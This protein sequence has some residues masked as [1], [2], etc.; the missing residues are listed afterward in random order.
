MDS[1]SPP[2][3]S[4]AAAAAAS[5]VPNASS[6][7]SSQNAAAAPL[8]FQ[9]PT[10]TLRFVMFQKDVGSII[11]KGGATIKTFREESGARINI[12]DSG[13]PER[14]V[15]IH[16]TT[17]GIFKAVAL[18]AKKFEEDHRVAL[19]SGTGTP[20]PPVS[21]R[22]L[23]PA[24]QC[25]PLIGKRGAR[26]KEIRESTRAALIQVSGDL[27]PGSTE[28][29]VTLSG[30][31]DALTQCIYHICC[32]IVENPPRTATVFYKPQM[33]PPPIVLPGIGPMS[34]GDPMVAV[35][36][37]DLSPPGH[38]PPPLLPP[39]NAA[40]A[41]AAAAAAVAASTMHATT[42]QTISIP[43]DLIGCLI[44]KRGAKITEIRQISGAQ[45]KISDPIQGLTHREV[46]ITGP[47]E[48]VGLA[49][50]LI[51]H[52]I[53]TE[54]NGPMAAGSPAGPGSFVPIPSSSSI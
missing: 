20:V 11:G 35:G 5:D 37:P 54:V 14:I 44:G 41:E 43:N 13:S 53:Q 16:G 40:Y 31:P 4:P 26:I 21:F 7:P 27:M 1:S 10:I 30:S 18:I 15:T 17:E 50:Y 39:G 51:N 3:S 23:L 2:S 9:Q 52:R 22:L 48:R 38:V 46:T 12:S 45:I 33:T 42:T 29:T 24:S 19:A 49:Q 6:L 25:G 34:L 32:I 28:R 47:S 8:A 36:A